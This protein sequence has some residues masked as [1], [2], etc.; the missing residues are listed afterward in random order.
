MSIVLGKGEYY[1][2]DAAWRLPEHNFQHGGERIAEGD[3]IRP[4]DETIL[5]IAGPK[6]GMGPVSA[7]EKGAAQ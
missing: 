5:G 3:Q 6:V 4:F 7:K 1:R 2:V